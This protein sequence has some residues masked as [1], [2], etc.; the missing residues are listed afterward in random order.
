MGTIAFLPVGIAVALSIL[1]VIKSNQSQKKFPK[2]LLFISIVL[3]LGAVGK[4]VLVK[5]KVTVDQQFIK[6]KEDSKQEAQKELEEL[7]GL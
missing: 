6:E 1:T 3:F 2:I 5:D 4:D 7:E